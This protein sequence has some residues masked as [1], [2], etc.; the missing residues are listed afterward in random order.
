M[1]LANMTQEQT[2]DYNREHCKRIAQDVHDYA[3]GRCYRCPERNETITLPDD[4]EDK[5]HCP[6]CGT[7]HEVDDLEQLSIWDWADNILDWRYIIERD[8]SYRSVEIMVAFGGPTIWISTESK[9]VELYWWGDRASYP[10]S[11]RAT[12]ALDEWAEEMWGV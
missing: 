11:Y 9:S 1:A 3:V 4:M 6:C 2:N 12:E 7:I 5:Y 8:K 10:I